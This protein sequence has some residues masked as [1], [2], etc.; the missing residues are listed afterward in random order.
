MNDLLQSLCET[1]AS[2]YARGLAFGSTGNLSVRVGGEIYV[3]PTGR[4]LKNLVPAELACVS[5]ED[6]SRLNENVASK[7]TPFH[8]A[9]YRKNPQAQA[10][11]HLHSTYAVAL[12][13]LDNLDPSQPLPCFTP[14]YR[15]RVEPL[16]VVPYYRPGSQ[17][18]A[19][20]MGNCAVGHNAILMR[21]HG[22]TT[23]GKKLEEA[24]DRYE[25]LEETAK[26]YFL[27]RSEKIRLLTGEEIADLDS[28][29]RSHG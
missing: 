22:A 7:E 1:A 11:V 29:F 5:L 12:S 8:I 6:G 10:L 14:Y 27:L 28:V 2:F 4:S 15:M 20:A 3:T 18:L 23:L 26:L 19:D 13:C 25:E 9:C 21:N 17:A 16:G 24:V